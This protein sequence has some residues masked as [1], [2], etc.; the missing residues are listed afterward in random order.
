MKTVLILVSLVVLSSLSIYAQEDMTPNRLLASVGFYNTDP[1]TASDQKVFQSVMDADWLIQP[2]STT[3]SFPVDWASNSTKNTKD[4]Y[5]K[6]TIL[7]VT[8]SPNG[9]AAPKVPYSISELDYSTLHQVTDYEYFR[10]DGGLKLR[11]F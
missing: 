3:A 7:R 11:L 4:S 9:S 10:K 1:P 6:D 2:S 5:L 8:A